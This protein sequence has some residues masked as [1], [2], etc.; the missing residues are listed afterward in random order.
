MKEENKLNA[1]ILSVGGTYEPLVTCMKEFKPDCVYF[2]HSKDTLKVTKDVIEK[3]NFKGETR[4]KEKSFR[5]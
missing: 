5:N 4:Y 2:L 3:S 1:L